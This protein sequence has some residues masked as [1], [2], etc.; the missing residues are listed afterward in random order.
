MNAALAMI[1]ALSVVS[2]AAAQEAP[3]QAPE[4]APEVYRTTGT[5]IAIGRSLHVPVDEEIDDAVVVVGGS[6]RIDGRVRN[7]V[8]VVGGHLDLGARADVRGETVVVGG[9]ITRAPGA[10]VRGQVTHISIADWRHWTL[11]GLSL[12]VLAFGDFG[13]WLT[14]FGTVFRVSLLAVLMALVILVAR[15]PVAR[16][17]RAAAAAPAKAF[18]LGVIAEVLFVP[19]LIVACVSLIITIVGI[20]LLLVVVPVALGGAFVALLLGFTA[21]ACQL[22]Q[23]IEDRLGWRGHSALLATGLGLLLVVGPTMLARAIGVA[24]DA[25]RFTALAL[26]AVGVTVEFVI[27]TMGLGATLMTGFGRWSTAPPP[28]PPVTASMLPVTN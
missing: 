28:A 25:L 26:L 7:G 24:P 21:L 14:L 17:G 18:A 20:P 6:A 22:G 27:W 12:P 15:A 10:Q 8:V 4:T 9:R 23:W 13:G 19:A 11:G 3:R 1:V 2:V 5:R 16:I